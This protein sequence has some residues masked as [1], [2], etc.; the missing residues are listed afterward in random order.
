MSTKTRKHH[1]KSYIYMYVYV[2]TPSAENTNRPYRD[3]YIGSQVCR[4]VTRSHCVYVCHVAH[5][6]PTMHVRAVLPLVRVPYAIDM[7]TVRV[8]CQDA[9]TQKAVATRLEYM[10]LKCRAYLREISAI[11]RHVQPFVLR[12]LSFPSYAKALHVGCC[13]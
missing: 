2:C 11:A 4:S 3:T 8:G 5:V 6:S 7:L 12:N 9:V 13:S 10:R 1:R